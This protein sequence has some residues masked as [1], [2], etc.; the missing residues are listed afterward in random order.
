MFDLYEGSQIS[1]QEFV[2]RKEEQA[3]QYAN[4]RQALAEKSQRLAKMESEEINR[5]TFREVLET[6]EKRWEKL[7]I[8]QKKRKLAAL[9][10]KIIIK[11]GSF[12]IHFRIGI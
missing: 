6:L 2:E 7:D 11:D 9:I 10:E 5:E 8:M 3:R 1:K 4:Y 12:K